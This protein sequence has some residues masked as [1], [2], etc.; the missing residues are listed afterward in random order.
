MQARRFLYVLLPVFTTGLLLSC[1]SG[2]KKDKNE[3]APTL[4]QPTFANTL[5]EKGFFVRAQEAWGAVNPKLPFHGN[6]HLALVATHKAKEAEPHENDACHIH[7]EFEG[8]YEETVAQ[9]MFL[10]KGMEAG[11]LGAFKLVKV[12][13]P[14]SAISYEATHEEDGIVAKATFSGSGNDNEVFLTA[15]LVRSGKESATLNLV[16]RAQILEKRM[17]VEMASD[18][19]D[20][21]EQI[22][23]D[24]HASKPIKMTVTSQ[25]TEANALTDV[26]YN[27]E[28]T[29]KANV[30]D[31]TGHVTSGD[32]TI[33]INAKVDFHEHCKHEDHHHKH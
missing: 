33:N 31:V 16:F 9:F 18:S 27:L 6:T 30:F 26:A 28:E 3:S 10:I 14:N 13:S 22:K 4:A 23:M 1:A 8:M 24:L 29:M 17:N 15:K 12:S 32:K 21:K 11:E 2:G 20:S 7:K 5:D 25:S 19:K